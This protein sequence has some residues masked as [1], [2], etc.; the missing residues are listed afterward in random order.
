MRPILLPLLAFLPLLSPP[1][2]AGGQEV[3][4]HR[5]HA[6]G[7]GDEAPRID[8]VLDEVVWERADPITGFR[9]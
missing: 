6:L 1:A 8:G 4:T 3:P 9:Q 7:D 5:V 2:L